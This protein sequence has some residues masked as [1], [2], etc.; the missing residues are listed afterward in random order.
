M[1]YLISSFPVLGL[2]CPG[3]DRKLVQNEQR[4]SHYVIICILALSSRLI[5][6]CL[7]QLKYMP[8]KKKKINSYHRW[9]DGI[10]KQKVPLKVLELGWTF[11]C[12]MMSSDIYIG[13]KGL[14]V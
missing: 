12:F 4:K 11:K 1:V 10:I 3:N 8:E 14:T 6:L 9:G 7:G 2:M 13:G 5:V